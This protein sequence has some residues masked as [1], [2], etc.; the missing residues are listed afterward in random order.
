[1]RIEFLGAPMD[2]L[3]FEE[4]VESALRA[5]RRR[6]PTM[7]VALNVAKFVKMRRDPE[8]ARDVEQADLIG[9]DGMG[10]VLAL[11]LFGRRGVERV[12]GVDLMFGLLDK[13]AELGMR[14]FVLGAR[15]EVLERAAAVARRRWPGLEFAGLADGYFSAEESDEVAARIRASGADCLFVAMPTPHKERF[16]NRYRR[17]LEVPF[18]MG[19]GGS[20][21][22]LAG[23]VSRAPAWMQRFA[24]EWLHRLVQEPRKMFWRYLSTNAAFAAIVARAWIDRL[25][26]REA[27]RFVPGR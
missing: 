9:I 16:L 27:V 5:M 14:P 2:L 21:D 7:H 26:G 1:M 6:T 20:I 3:T 13:C 18:I 25:F 23:S 11:G 8:L 10:L 22:V 17:T 4:T 19:V 24:L 12:A 15:G